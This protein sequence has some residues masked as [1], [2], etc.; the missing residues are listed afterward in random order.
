M[1][2]LSLCQHGFTN[3]RFADLII[4]PISPIAATSETSKCVAVEIIA[5]THVPAGNR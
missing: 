4:E 2:C 3:D 5:C 1:P